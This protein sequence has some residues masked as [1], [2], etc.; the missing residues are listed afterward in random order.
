MPTSEETM[1]KVNNQKKLTS[2]KQ[3][4]TD[5]ASTPYEARRAQANPKGI[6]TKSVDT[7]TGSKAEDHS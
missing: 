1:K 3:S 2:S 5:G 7:G 6:R 4:A